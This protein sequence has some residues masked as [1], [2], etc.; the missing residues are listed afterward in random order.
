MHQKP[1]P[2]T[3]ADAEG[4]QRP[5]GLKPQWG[6]EEDSVAVVLALRPKSSLGDSWDPLEGHCC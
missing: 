4:I 1:S 6:Y 5:W 2:K 3:Y